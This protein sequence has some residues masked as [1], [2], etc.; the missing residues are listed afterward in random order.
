MR[1]TVSPYGVVC[2]SAERAQKK[3]V[4]D[5]D[6]LSGLPEKSYRFIFL[7]LVECAS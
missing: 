1:Y 5:T 2:S 6:C 7:I 3:D 4:L